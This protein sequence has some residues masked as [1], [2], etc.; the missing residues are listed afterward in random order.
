MRCLV[1]ARYS[2]DRQTESSIED[3]LRVCREFAQSRGWHV[4]EEFSDH[5][6]SGAALGNRPGAL[7]AIA[8]LG[9]GDALL[10]NDLSRLFRSQDLAPL[11]ARI[12]HRGARVFGVQ[13]GF[14]S[15][16]DTARMQAG[17]SGIMSEEFRK[18]VALRTH[19]ALKQRARDGKPTGGKAF[20]DAE[21]IQEIFRRFA[22]G[23]SMKEIASDLNRRGIP[24][25]GATWKERNRPRGKWQVSTLHAMLHNELYVGRHVWNRSKWVKDPDTGK[26]CRRERPESE[27]IV[28]AVPALVDEETWARAQARMRVRGGKGGAPRY[29]LSGLLVCGV[30]GGKL[31]VTGGGQHRYKCGTR[32][33]GGEHAC[34]NGVSVPRVIAE[35]L[36]LAPVEADLLSPEAIEAGVREMR[37]ARAEAERVPQDRDVEALE[38]LVREGLLTPE[39][40]APSLE[41]ARA[42]ARRPV[43]GLPWP[44]ADAWRQTVKGMRE[45]LHGEDVTQARA[46]LR[47]LIGEVR[48]VP[49]DGYLV[50]E[51]TAR[52]IL[53][54]TGTGRWVGSGGA[55][56]IR[57]PT[58]TRQVRPNHP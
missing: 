31:I 38:R 23:D 18:M 22:D 30:C 37:A 55:L 27:W 24:S 25:P 49:E 42:R 12:D 34:S 14:D 9:P 13:D 17:L 20:E 51:L 53:L 35:E 7:R 41:A 4:A 57:L 48:C 58:S 40:A 56:R 21:I 52:R 8:A 47:E 6:I 50:A 11:V 5:G 1:Y 46:I 39:A 36:I 32:H 3:Q 54:A 45:L 44:T 33:A 29:L 16:S 26:R 28:R 43:S 2:T 15:H 19:S 10:V